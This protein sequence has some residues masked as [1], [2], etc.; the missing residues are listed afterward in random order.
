[1]NDG[2]LFSYG[3][4]FLMEFFQLPDGYSFSDVNEVINHT[5]VDSKGALATLS[6]GAMLPEAYRVDSIFRERIFFSCAV[7]GI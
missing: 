1:M 5:F 3:T 2:R 6:R 7:D 4:T